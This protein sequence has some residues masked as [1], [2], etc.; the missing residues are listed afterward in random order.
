MQKTDYI[1]GT[2]DAYKSNI[3][4]TMI[5][6][7][8]SGVREGKNSIGCL[9]DLIFDVNGNCSSAS[10]LEWFG[11]SVCSIEEVEYERVHFRKPTICKKWFLNAPKW[12]LD[13]NK[14]NYKKG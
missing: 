8:V 4:T 7:E 13:K 6:V 14:V 5:R 10:R 9:V 11:K 2:E 3:G 12:I 1:S